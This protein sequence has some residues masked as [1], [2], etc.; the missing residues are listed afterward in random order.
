MRRFYSKRV[1]LGLL[2][3]I[4]IV[5]TF[6]YLLPTIADYRDVWRVVQGVSW[7]W[8]VALVAVTALN[9]LTFAPR[10][11]CSSGA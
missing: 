2:G 10:G 1:L 4:L 7:E 8:T 11:S 6:A 3:G 5:A 9:I